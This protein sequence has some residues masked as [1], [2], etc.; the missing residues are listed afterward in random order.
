[1][2]MGFGTVETEPVSGAELWKTFRAAFLSLLSPVIILGGIFSGFTTATE[3][4]VIA[5]VYSF[6]LSL[7]YRELTMKKFQEIIVSSAVTSATIL[8]IISAANSLVYVLTVNR[9]P[10][11][12]SDFFLQFASTPI[13]FLLIV[14]LILLVLGMFLDVTALIVLLAPIFM[15]IALQYGI[16]P[17]HFGMVLI[18]NF[19]LANVTPPVGLSLIAGAGITD[20]QMGIEDTFPYILHVIGI[21]L[22][23]VLA[24]IF[25]PSISTTIPNYFF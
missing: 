10:A 9:I 5:V 15:P 8:I 12:I 22:I 13:Q 25:I 23:V 18:M 2:K 6:I 20:K 24:I 11:M 21:L 14:S 4:A 16:D 17:V 3:A 7:L 19:A 1:R